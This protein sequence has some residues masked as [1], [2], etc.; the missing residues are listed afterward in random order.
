MRQLFWSRAK[1]GCYVVWSRTKCGRY[2]EEAELS[3]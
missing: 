1:G 3:E 2:V